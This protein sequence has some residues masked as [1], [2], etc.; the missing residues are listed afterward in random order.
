V[1]GAANAKPHLAAALCRPVRPPPLPLPQPKYTLTTA[2][3]T[4]TEN[5]VVDVGGQRNERRKWVHCFENVR[6]VVYLVGLSGYNQCLFEDA[7]VNRM[8]ESL[9]LFRQVRVCIVWVC[10]GC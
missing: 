10:P 8:Q 3:A 2:T 9:K 1:P 7:S 6:A 4:A 5:R